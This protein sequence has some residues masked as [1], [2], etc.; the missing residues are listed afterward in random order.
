MEDI[1]RRILDGYGV[2]NYSLLPVQKGYRNQSFAARL[3]DGSM[4]NLVVYKREPDILER[5]KRTNAVGDYTFQHGLPAR[6]TRHARIVRL[7][8]L[9]GEAFAALYDYLP[10]HT[11]PWE[12]YTMNHLKLL[13]KTM[14]DLHAALQSYENGALPDVIDEYL[15]I[16][17]RMQRYFAQYGVQRALAAKLGLATPANTHERIV[18]TLNACQSLPH[19]QALHMD[20]VRSN[21]LF[22]DVQGE[23]AVTG[24]L[25]FEKTARGSVLF[26][27]A[28]TLAFLLV[29][30][31]YKQPDKIRKY[32]LYSGY[33][34]RSHSGFQNVVINTKTGRID[35]LEALLDIFLVY[36]FYKFLRH[37]PYEPLL[38]NEHFVRTRDILVERGLLSRSHIA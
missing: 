6:H 15:V 33:R 13:G 11:I 8:S 17:G 20:F 21:I 4:V 34:K 2:A 1:V 38:Q 22:D 24:I 25:D 16:A 14:G 18:A 5:I 19:Q 35:V 32:F 30:C 23:L 31:K 12:G 29:D 7:S 36:D 9:R 26:D 37:N 3:R 28:R 10:G 27:I